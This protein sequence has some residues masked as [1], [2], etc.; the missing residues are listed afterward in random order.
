MQADLLL[1][2]G[3]FLIVLPYQGLLRSA[4][5]AVGPSTPV[6]SKSLL[7]SALGLN[8][9]EHACRLDGIRCHTCAQQAQQCLG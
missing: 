3:V 2:S 7:E 1:R 6:L 8:I 5:G 4:L 9:Q